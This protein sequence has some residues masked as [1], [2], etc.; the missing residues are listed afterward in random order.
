MKDFIVNKTT[1]VVNMAKLLQQGSVT[2]KYNLYALI[3]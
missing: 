2:H 3:R 1:G